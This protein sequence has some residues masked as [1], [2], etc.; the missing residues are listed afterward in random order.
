MELGLPLI[1]GLLTQIGSY[2]KLVVEVLTPFL[3]NAYNAI[4]PIFIAI[5]M[6]LAGI[7]Y[8]AIVTSRIFRII[9]IIIGLFFVGYAYLSMYHPKTLQK[10][11]DF[12]TLVPQIKRDIFVFRTSVDLSVESK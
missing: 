2:I 1:Q 8:F 3:K 6:F 9:L 7:D 12:L 4:A 5:F 11:K 10:I